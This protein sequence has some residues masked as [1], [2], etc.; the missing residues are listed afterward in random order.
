MVTIEP[1]AKL[2]EQPL[3]GYGAKGRADCIIRREGQPTIIIDFKWTAV[4]YRNPSPGYV[5]QLLL[6]QW[7]EGQHYGEEE[8]VLRRN[9]TSLYFNIM[10]SVPHEMVGFERMPK[11]RGVRSY[12]GG[13]QNHAYTHLNDHL[14][15]MLV[16]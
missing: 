14:L 4:N 16:V 1:T 5:L 11:Y 8:G 3:V 6:Y 13:L 2:L 10:V 7:M 15:C 12:Y 9:N